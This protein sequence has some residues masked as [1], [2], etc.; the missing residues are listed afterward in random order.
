MKILNA[1]NDVLKMFEVHLAARWLVRHCIWIIKVTY[2]PYNRLD[3]H[4]TAYL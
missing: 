1:R 2:T 3:E 4:P